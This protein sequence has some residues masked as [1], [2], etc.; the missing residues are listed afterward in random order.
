MTP[1]RQIATSKI[2]AVDYTL[3][4]TTKGYAIPTWLVVNTA[5]NS[6]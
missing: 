6:V 3:R 5:L 1:N 2:A 4:R